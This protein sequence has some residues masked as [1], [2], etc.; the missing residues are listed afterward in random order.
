MSELS[1]PFTPRPYVN[2]IDHL[3]DEFA[4][5]RA[6]ARHLSARIEADQEAV[7]SLS[8][9]G[10]VEAVDA[11]GD[12][13]DRL[14]ALEQ[15][16]RERID[17]RL[18]ATAAAGRV[19]GLEKLVS[20]YGLDEVEQMALL[21]CLIPTTGLDLY[22]TLGDLGSYGF[23]IMSVSPEMVAVFSDLDLEGR[24]RLIKGLS[25]EGPLARAG[26]VRVGWNAEDDLNDFWTAGV[27]LTSKAQRV[28]VGD[29]SVD[30]RSLRSPH[31]ASPRCSAM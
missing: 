12:K 8:A 19:L 25:P 16:L 22:R 11:G 13:V 15:T 30:D 10:P 17:G 24:L 31:S 27:Y 7:Q 1:R 20:E 6:R 4:W 26:L 23:G 21:L 18:E 3:E 9:A 5:V 28:L 29:V 2:D 14:A